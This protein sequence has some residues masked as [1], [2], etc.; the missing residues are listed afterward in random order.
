MTEDEFE[1]DI[2]D[3]D[4][5]FQVIE[6]I[7]RLS[8]IRWLLAHAVRIRIAAFLLDRTLDGDTSV[9]VEELFEGVR[10]PAEKVVEQLRFMR[11]QG[12]VTGDFWV[13]DEIVREGSVG[14]VPSLFEYLL[15]A[16]D[17]IGPPPLPVPSGP[18]TYTAADKPPT[19]APTGDD[20]LAHAYFMLRHEETDVRAHKDALMGLGAALADPLNIDILIELWLGE[21]GT[22]G[23]VVERLEAHRLS[24]E[25]R[26]QNEDPNHIAG[27]PIDRALIGGRLREL[28]DLFVIEPVPRQAGDWTITDPM[29]KAL[30]GFLPYLQA[31]RRLADAAKPEGPHHPSR[32]EPGLN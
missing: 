13:H 10:V 26:R 23:D 11:H 25:Q 19:A 3:F 20:L 4:G 31:R 8:R 12:A 2:S 21:H 27:L 32:D 15:A 29:R 30:G 16:A 9:R 7:E 24:I 22:T 5:P 6:L 14:L 17:T 18:S 28:G 1:L